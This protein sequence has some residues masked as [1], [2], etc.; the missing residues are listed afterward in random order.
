MFRCWDKKL[1]AW[2][3][4]W[5]VRGGHTGQQDNFKKPVILDLYR[6]ID[7]GDENYVLM[8]YTGL[9]DKSVKEVYEGDVRKDED[10]GIY[11]VEQGKG[12]W[13]IRFSSSD[14]EGNPTTLWDVVIPLD[15]HFI[16]TTKH[17]GTIYENPELL[18]E[19]PLT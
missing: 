4:M 7:F 5:M 14:K 1:K 15:Q 10:G 18:N 2:A 12:F 3:G 16:D 13:G 8:Q 17:I 11:I 6:S 9:K 19:P